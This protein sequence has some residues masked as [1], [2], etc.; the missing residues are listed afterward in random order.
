M[1][2]K[3]QR[4]HVTY[5]VNHYPEGLLEHEVPQGLGAC[6][7]VVIASVVYPPDGS[8]SMNFFGIDGRD[9]HSVTDR[10]L[11][12]AWM[13]LTLNLVRK[14]YDDHDPGAMKEWHHILIEEAATHVQHALAI[15]EGKVNGEQPRP[16]GG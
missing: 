3:E 4:F 16:L 15:A 13:M 6:D 8:L 10:E 5:E 9:G 1:A 11:W 14:Q 2:A 7:A 12:K